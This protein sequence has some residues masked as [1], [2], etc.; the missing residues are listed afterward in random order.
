MKTATSTQFCNENELRAYPLAEDSTMLSDQGVALPTNLL[1]DMCVMIPTGLTGV[2]LA[3]VSI[4]KTMVSLSIA[5]DQGALLVGT[6]L[7]AS[8]VQYGS[9]PLTPVTSN[10]SGWVTF[11]S[12]G[13]TPSRYLFATPAQSKLETRGVRVSPPPGVTQFWREGSDP[14]AIATG[15]VKLEV[16]GGLVT[17]INPHNIQN[18]LFRLD[19]TH[20]PIYALPCGQSVGSKCVV[21]A[22]RSINNVPP[23][24]AGAITLR[25]I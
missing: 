21:P 10:V 7:K 3:S 23:D 1:A 17:Y 4:T 13:L 6:Y 5:C 16:S 2:R 8:M 24:A 19:A 15:L 22:I 14:G 11:G 25:F 20:Q 18:I 12:A 9:Y